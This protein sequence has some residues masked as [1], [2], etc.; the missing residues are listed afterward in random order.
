MAKRRQDEPYLIAT[1]AP[2]R[3]RVLVVVYS[4][5]YCEAFA[6]N[7]NID[8]KFVAAPNVN[9]RLPGA[10]ALVQN[11]VDFHLPRCYSDI[12]FPGAAKTTGYALGLKPSEIADSQLMSSIGLG[13]RN[14]RIDR[15]QGKVGV[16]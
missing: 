15:P 3:E 5:G 12:Y 4:D 9:M 11:Y 6:S 16:A 8:I 14:L 10:E 7:T 1:A 13:F 2:P